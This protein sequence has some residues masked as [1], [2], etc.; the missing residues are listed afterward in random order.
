MKKFLSLL[1][2]ILVMCSLAVTAFASSSADLPSVDDKWDKDNYPYAFM[3]YVPSGG[4]YNVFFSATKPYI[5]NG[6]VKIDKVGDS[7]YTYVRYVYTAS[8]PTLGWRY[9]DMSTNG[10]TVHISDFP[11]IESSVDLYDGNTLYL[12]ADGDFFPYPLAEQI[13][14]VTSGAMEETMPELGGTMTTLMVCGVGCLA[15]LVVLKLF[16][17]RSLIF[18]S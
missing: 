18:R 2:T 7:Q 4:E 13:L 14:A 15:L 8:N 10:F 1:M 16:G 6:Q 12:K 17:K 3:Y 5:E 9:S 11:V